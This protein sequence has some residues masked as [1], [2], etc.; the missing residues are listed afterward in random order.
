MVMVDRE[1]CT[2]FNVTDD[3][4]I[5]GKWIVG[6]VVSV[7]LRL[8]ITAYQNSGIGSKAILFQLGSG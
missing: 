8:A 6:E 1:G 5:A 2:D 3:G 4:Q 7:E